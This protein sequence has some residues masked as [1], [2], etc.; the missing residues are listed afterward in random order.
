[1]GHKWIYSSVVGT[2]K[3]EVDVVFLRKRV[4]LREISFKR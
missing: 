3:S 4:G 1:M 2:E